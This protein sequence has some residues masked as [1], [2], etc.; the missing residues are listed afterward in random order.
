MYKGLKELTGELGKD[1]NRIIVIMKKGNIVT[2]GTVIAK[3]KE[4][5]T[6]KHVR[7]QIID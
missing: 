1:N 7:F 3:S 4:D 5:G 2:N 6:I